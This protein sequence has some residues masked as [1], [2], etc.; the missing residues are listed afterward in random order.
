MHERDRLD[1][2][3]PEAPEIVLPRFTEVTAGLRRTLVS[4]FWW[5]EDV[6]SSRVFRPAFRRLNGK[7][8]QLVMPLAASWLSTGP[9]APVSEGNIIAFLEGVDPTF[10]HYMQ[11]LGVLGSYDILSSLDD[12]PR[13]SR[14]YNRPIYNVDDLPD[15]WD[16]HSK[17]KAATVRMV[18]T[19]KYLREL[20]SFSAPYEIVDLQRTTAED[21][22]RIAG[23]EQILF[24]KKNNTENTSNGVLI[25]RS[26]EEYMETV[27]QLRIEAERYD[28]DF[29]IVLQG[30]IDGKNRSFQFFMTPEDPGHL[31]LLAHSFQ[32]TGADGK[33]YLGNENPPL[34]PD[35]ITPNL[36]AMVL[37]MAERIRSIDP[38]TFGF[39]MCDYFETADGPLTFDPGLRATG[40]TATLLAGLFAEER[41]N[42]GIRRHNQ[43][44]GAALPD[45]AEMSF[46][47]FIRPVD[48]LMDPATVEKGEPCV[49]PWGYNQH[50]GKGL[51]IA[52]GRTREEMQGVLCDAASLLQSPR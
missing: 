48:R 9:D 44:F 25:C 43:L 6:D 37:D 10:L 18:N 16:L 22:V 2:P 19:K 39:V 36:R 26:S 32:L 41:A 23:A 46:E 17:N 45:A 7:G 13:L 28:L 35:A 33:S 20:S 5:D 52:I 12:L 31:P 15:A 40:N 47:T 34:T 38:Q 51:F 49:L 42:D 50:Q 27:E 29:E 14:Y 4:N 11:R 24:L 21:F 1:P 30:K 8:S 3:L